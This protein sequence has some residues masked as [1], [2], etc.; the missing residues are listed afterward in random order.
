MATMKDQRDQTLAEHGFCLFPAL[1]TAHESKDSWHLI[2]LPPSNIDARADVDHS[3]LFRLAWSIILRA[4]S[5]KDEPLFIYNDRTTRQNGDGLKR[6]T[7]LRVDL[8]NECISQ[9]LLDGVSEKV[10]AID[11]QGPRICN[12]AISWGRGESDS[13]EIIGKPTLSIAIHA[14]VDQGDLRMLFRYRLSLLSDDQAMQVMD[15]L[16]HVMNQLIKA[17]PMNSIELCSEKTYSQLLQW[18]TG[19]IDNEPHFVHDLIVEQCRNRPEELAVRAWDGNLTY[20]DLDFES[21]K[22]ARRLVGEGVGPGTYI[23]LYF[24]KSKWTTVSVLAILRSGAAYVFLDTSFP[25]DRLEAMCQQVG[26]GI[27]L[28]PEH[29]IHE[30]RRLGRNV[31]PIDDGTVEASLPQDHIHDIQLT[32]KRPPMPSDAAYVSFSS[33]STGEPKGSIVPHSSYTFAQK[34]FTEYVGLTS[35]SKLFQ[36]SSYG[37]DQVN[38]EHLSPLMVGACICVPSE[39]DRRDNIPKAMKQLGANTLALTPTVARHLRPS[40]LPTLDT[41]LLQGEP[42]SQ[43]DMHW[44]HHCHVINGY[45]PSECSGYTTAHHFQPGDKHP[46]VIGRGV[47]SQCWVVDPGDPQRLMPIGAIGE[48]LIEGPAVGDGYIA[49]GTKTKECFIDSPCWRSKFPGNPARK[50]YLTGD[51]V[52][53]VSGGELRYLGR[54]FGEAKLRGQRLELSE[55]EYHVRQVF[56]ED[57]SVVAELVIPKDSPKDSKILVAFVKYRHRSQSASDLSESLFVPPCPNFRVKAQ[58]ALAQIRDSLPSFMVPS[59]VLELSTFPTTRT[60]KTDRARLRKQASLL[61]R[62]EL[63]DYIRTRG[64]KTAP[65]TKNEL[66]LHGLVKQVLCLGE[67]GMNDNFFSLGG[68]SILTMDL[69][70]LCRDAG[71]DL[72]SQ[73]IFETPILAEMAKSITPCAVE[74]EVPEFSLLPPNLVK[75]EALKAA[76]SSCRLQS[77]D[78]IEDIY[79]CTPLQEGLMAASLSGKQG[80]YLI[81]ATYCLPKFIDLGRLKEAWQTAVRNSQILRT[82]IIHTTFDRPLQVVTRTPMEWEQYDSIDKAVSAAA[83]EDMTPG[84]PLL[85]LKLVHN[86]HTT[87]LMVI[88]HHAICDGW[89]Y[90]QMLSDVEQAYYDVVTP[91]IPFKQFV[92]YVESLDEKKVYEFWRTEL[93]SFDGYIFPNP[94]SEIRRGKPSSKKTLI[95]STNVEIPKGSKA[96]VATVLKLAWALT[97]SQ[98]SGSHDVVFGYVVSGR[99]VPVM[100]IGK[101]A[102]P[103]FSSIP[104]RV[105]LDR[106]AKVVDAL[107]DLQT[108]SARCLPFEQVRLS[109]ISALSPGAAAA[110][111]FQTLLIVQPWQADQASSI[112]GSSPDQSYSEE[113]VDDYMLVVEVKLGKSAAVDIEFQYDV[114]A[115]TTEFAHAVIDQFLHSVSEVTRNE[116]KSFRSMSLVNPTDLRRIYAWN[117]HVPE[118][119]DCCVHDVI[120]RHCIS[121][122]ERPAVVA[123]DG[124][125]SYGELKSRATKISRH[126]QESGVGPG[127]YVMI[128]AGKS[129]WTVVAMMAVMYSGGSFILV[130]PAQPMSRLHQIRDDTKASLVL[131]ISSL[132]TAAAGLGIQVVVID[133][134]QLVQAQTSTFQNAAVA[135]TNIVYVVFTSGTTGRPKGVLVSH[136]AFLTSAVINGGAQHIDEK[137]RVLQLASFTFDASIAEILYP[138]VHG[139]CICIPSEQECRTSL[140][141]SMNKYGVAW[142]TLTPSLARTLNPSKLTTLKALA[143]G[144][145]AVKQIDVDMWADKVWLGNGYGP[146]E[147]SVDAVVQ[148]RIR[149]G[150]DPSV[151]G[152][153]VAGV[154]WIVDPV[155]HNIVK[156][157]GSVGE[158]LLEGPTLAEGYLND[159]EKTS[160]A[161]V[162]YPDWLLEL[163]GGKQG[164]LYKT[165][166]LVQY[167]LHLDGKIQYVG[168]KDTQVKLR[169]QRIEVGEVEH[170]LRAT[171]TDATDVIAEVVTPSDADSR[172]VLVAFVVMEGAECFKDDLFI[173]ADPSMLHRFGKPKAVLRDILPE[174]MV[175]SLFI[176]LARVPLTSNGKI[177][178]RLLRS[179]VSRRSRRELF[180]YE[181]ADTVKKQ[182]QTAGEILLQKIVAFILKVETSEV[183]MNDYFSQLGADSI[184]AMQLVWLI[185]ENGFSLHMKDVLGRQNLQSLA[186]CISE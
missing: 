128:Q 151:I 88:I 129:L 148:P 149:S 114:E 54:K 133:Q 166:D 44:T 105:K 32:T 143:L 53:Y 49:N 1:N 19:P 104:L 43:D 75:E 17:Q 170:H 93:D 12:T 66:I 132:S 14:W 80:N 98:Y 126:L 3:A 147:S 124:D 172:P 140:E 40:E 173:P 177:D 165:G 74:D 113:I 33:G 28:C 51:L 9:K 160:T 175:P 136:R 27:I 181:T 120:D 64:R 59:I 155:D 48:L 186:A 115:M 41:L 122:S 39:E 47:G 141:Q 56:G 36:F 171:I 68:D 116:D 110:C 57:T 77:S 11:Y 29:L 100:N 30:A 184:A 38:Y 121:A 25:N 84:K 108:H 87:H 123:W 131:T 71:F 4:Y 152:R 55:V 102:G 179:E 46:A 24:R 174:Y 62:D 106:D 144:G 153:S 99:S 164:R 112:F 42:L 94:P 10:L 138:L 163:R 50:L 95:R 97:Q 2:T 101:I 91:P 109:R 111:K 15:S 5:G 52:Q 23:G 69:T 65:A 135:P 63:E 26:I 103:T 16:I 182:P 125:L 180:A 156:P 67:F 37:F 137:S 96:T 90:T 18:F 134:E 107:Q 31:L 185:Q 22:V 21:D 81:S 8:P 157:V 60:G 6:N 82:R 130:D 150:D 86:G 127:T 158:L 58:A 79:P 72:L 146:A 119:I 76:M 159:P 7:V 139:G 20:R 167:S 117:N 83:S 169:G 13:E 183:G 145:E 92:K 178:R 78:E 73:T 34:R 118:P 61:S 89:S 45:G 154:S 161:F 176:P 168:R 162:E 35:A 142:A 85:R 70:R